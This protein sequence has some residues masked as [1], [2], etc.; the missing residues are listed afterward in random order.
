ME[1]LI[2]SY[3][4]S[5]TI[6]ITNSVKTSPDSFSQQLRVEVRPVLYYHAI[7]VMKML[8]NYSDAH[9]R[10]RSESPHHFAPPPK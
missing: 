5:Y 8:F 10:N 2:L 3:H 1:V 9:H 4:S 6:M 7:I